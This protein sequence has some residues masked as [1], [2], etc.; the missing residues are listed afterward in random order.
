MAGNNNVAVK[1]AGGKPPP[2]PLPLPTMCKKL[3]KMSNSDFSEG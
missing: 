2:P 3:A 1:K